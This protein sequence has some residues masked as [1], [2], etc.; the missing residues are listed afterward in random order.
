MTVDLETYKKL[1][2]QAE[3]AKAQANRAAGA[4]EQLMGELYEKFE[5]ST[6]DEANALLARLEKQAQ[7][8]EEVYR[9]ELTYFESEWGDYLD[10]HT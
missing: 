3:Q 7:A 4:V 1:K 10:Q 8:A 5:C 2:D 6:L 9:D